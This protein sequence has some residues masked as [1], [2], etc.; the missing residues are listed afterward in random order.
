MLKVALYADD[1]RAIVGMILDIDAQENVFLSAG[2]RCLSEVTL[3][4]VND[5][6]YH[7]R[8]FMRYLVAIHMPPYRT[9][10]AS[11]YTVRN[12]RIIAIYHKT[13]LM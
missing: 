5:H 10:L 12:A 8:I 7:Y 2:H 4:L 6:G 13:H 11:K 1:S 3:E 9:L